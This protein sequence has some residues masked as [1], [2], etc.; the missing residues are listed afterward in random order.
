[1]DNQEEVVVEQP[2]TEQSQPEVD[3]SFEAGFA[4]ARGETPPVEAEPAAETPV[5]EPKV[6]EPQPI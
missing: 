4:E 6:V 5:E 3:T 2:A 1:M